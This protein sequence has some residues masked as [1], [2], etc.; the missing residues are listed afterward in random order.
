[1]LAAFTTSS[2][3]CRRFAD[4]VLAHV[5]QDIRRSKRPCATSNMRVLPVSR[6][7]ATWLFKSLR[8]GLTR[9]I[10]PAALRGCHWDVFRGP[11]ADSSRSLCRVHRIGEHH[12]LIRRQLVQQRFIALDEGRLLRRVQLARD[13]LRLAMFHP[14]AMQQGDQT[15]SALIR[16]AAFQHDPCPDLTGGPWQRLGDPRRQPFPVLRRQPAGT[17]FVAKTRQALDPI[18]LIQ[19]MPCSDRVVV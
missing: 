2:S 1:M 5:S 12:R 15:C 13:R 7:I 6:S 18:L 14:K 4:G 17:P 3:G 16:N 9:G 19:P 10:P 8:L 11:A